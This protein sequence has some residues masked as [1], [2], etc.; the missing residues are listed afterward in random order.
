MLRVFNYVAIGKVEERLKVLDYTIS[1]AERF[2]LRHSLRIISAFMWFIPI[3]VYKC[4]VA[5]IFPFFHSV[6]NTYVAYI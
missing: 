2:S 6:T 1:H 5:I 4:M 3:P